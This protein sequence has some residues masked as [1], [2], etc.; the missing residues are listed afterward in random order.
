MEFPAVFLLGILDNFGHRHL[1]GEHVH[2][3]VVQEDKEH[4]PTAQLFDILRDV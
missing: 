1:P 2:A 4:L 3:V